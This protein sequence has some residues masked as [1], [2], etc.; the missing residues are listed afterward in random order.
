NARYDAEGNKLPDEYSDALS[1]LRGFAKSDLSSS[2]VFSA[3]YNPKL[4][5]YTEQFSDFFPDENGFVK[6]KIIL[7][8][9][10]L[11]SAMVQGRILAKKGIWVSEFRIESGLNCGG[12]AFATEGHLM[13]PILAEFKARLDELNAELLTV[14]A[15]AL[16]EGGHLP[17]DPSSRFRITVQ[18]GI[19][20]A[21]E[22]RFL[23][24][25]YGMDGTGWGS[26]FLLVP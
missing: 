6:K 20:T 4:Y 3:G 22:D 2:V 15:K 19:G 9:S 5:S 16:A 12:H 7:K 25:H 21:E 24:S 14:C 17:L 18:G 13:G 23:R 11:R 1:A 8:V 26:P 10:D